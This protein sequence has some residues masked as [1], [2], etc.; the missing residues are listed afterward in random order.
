MAMELTCLGLGKDQETWAGP[1][2]HLLQVG[3]AH[4]L[5]ECPLDLAMLHLFLPAANITMRNHQHIRLRDATRGSKRADTTIDTLHHSNV[6][7]QCLAVYHEDDNDDQ[8]SW[9]HLDDMQCARHIP[10]RNYREEERSG[11]LLRSNGPPENSSYSGFTCVIDGQTFLD[12]EPWYKTAE[13]AALD[14]SSLDAV[15]ISNPEGMLGLPFLTHME[16]FSGKIY[17][18][19]VTAKLGQLMMEELVTMHEEYVQSFGRSDCSK[20][21]FW[22]NLPAIN[23]YPP[24]L[25]KALV[26]DDGVGRANWQCLYRKEDVEICMKQVQCLHY[27]E[28]VSIYDCLGIKPSSSGSELGASNWIISGARRLSYFSASHFTS[29]HSMALNVN[30]HI[31]SEIFLFTDLK[32]DSIN[33]V[34]AA[35]PSCSLGEE[36][37]QDQGEAQSRHEVNLVQELPQVCEAIS[38][39]VISGG[40]VL[41]LISG[42]GAFLEALEAIAQTFDN[43]GLSDVPLFF[44]SPVAEELLVY[45]NTIP[46]WLCAERQEKLYAGEALFRHVELLQ[47]KRLH[48]LSSIYSAK[49]IKLWKEPCVVFAV[50]WGLRLGP[51]VP[52]IHRWR[53][54]ARCLLVLSQ[55]GINAKLALAPFQPLQMKV[56]Q[57][58]RGGKL[59][60][61]EVSAIIEKLKPEMS[62]VSEMMRGKLE[63]LLGGDCKGS[64]DNTAFYNMWDVLTIPGPD[65]VEADMAAEVACSIR[66]KQL[67]SGIAISQVTMS[68][69][70]NKGKWLLD[71]PKLPEGE[72]PSFIGRVREDIC[73]GSVTVTELVNILQEHGLCCEVISKEQDNPSAENLCEY[74]IDI[75]SPSPAKV[76][77]RPHCTL[78]ETEDTS[79]RELI[80]D[81]VKS[82]LT[83]I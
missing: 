1:S 54:D 13:F 53:Q 42:I 4:L 45:S 27:D 31:L 25:K 36:E 21:P 72:G 59:G 5:L 29:G 46:E 16:E 79:M 3:G 9:F 41:V 10:Q 49:V 23:G 48:Q 73:W 7:R 17:A 74:C 58:N 6:K 39:A 68:V 81:A 77:L 57:Y 50:N 24:F 52:L 51:A 60:E 62:L 26:D 35:I 34:D 71:V 66:P 12:V 67:D 8:I 47:Q 55:A 80:T 65:R 63:P 69:Q 22:L 78:I 56:L 33:E 76:E 2:C 32:S 40:S 28:E 70:Q 64:T 30:S 14:V 82:F 37:T 43:S 19:C 11:F 75:S 61:T 44:I 38:E 15:L 83:F 18:T 20:K